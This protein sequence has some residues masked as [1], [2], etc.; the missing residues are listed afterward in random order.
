VGDGLIIFI[1]QLFRKISWV[2]YLLFKAV[3]FI[4]RAKLLIPKKSFNKRAAVS[5][6]KHSTVSLSLNKRK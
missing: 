1:S 5:R 6:V 3:D 4:I 2:F